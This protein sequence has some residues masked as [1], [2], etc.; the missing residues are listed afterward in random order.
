ML[1]KSNSLPDT[2]QIDI[3]ID[4]DIDTKETVEQNEQL[5]P[6]LNNKLTKKERIKKRL[7]EMILESTIHG[8][9]NVLKTDA[10]HLKIIWI[11]LFLVTFIVSIY[12]II[13]NINDY[14]NYEVTTNIDL[15]YEQPV[16]FPTVS[17]QFNYGYSNANY[18]LE[19]NII[20]MFYG[21]FECKNLKNEFEKQ[22]LKSGNTYYK[23]NS[24]Y[25]LNGDVIDIK[26]QKVA[27]YY[28][29]NLNFIFN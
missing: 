20:K 1:I 4:I 12:M 22:V 16:I 3:K 21:K 5:L 15:V 2:L 29:G 10:I 7:R 8:L 26:Y 28:G 27:G 23:F 24:G 9:P 14:L 18:S 19:N 11:C 6:I 13:G 17:F 25:N